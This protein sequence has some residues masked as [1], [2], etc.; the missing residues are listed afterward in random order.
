M[1][2]NS[3]FKQNIVYL[4]DKKVFKKLLLKPTLMWFE[5]LLPLEEESGSTISPVSGLL[6]PAISKIETNEEIYLYQY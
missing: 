6:L 2:H 1:L 3:L 5:S 4:N